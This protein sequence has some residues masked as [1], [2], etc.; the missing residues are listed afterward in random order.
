MKLGNSRKEK[1]DS[2]FAT[3]FTSMSMVIH[4]TGYTQLKFLNGNINSQL[5]PRRLST[6]IRMKTLLLHFEAYYLLVRHLEKFQTIPIQCYAK[7]KNKD[8]SAILKFEKTGKRSKKCFNLL[9]CGCLH[10]ILCLHF[11]LFSNWTYIFIRVRRYRIQKDAWILDAKY[12]GYKIPKLRVLIL[13][14]EK[15]K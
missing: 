13:S 3:F 8:M 2:I 10:I 9:L 11:L 1:C 12:R 7:D 5:K 14:Y 15:N 6:T 4:V